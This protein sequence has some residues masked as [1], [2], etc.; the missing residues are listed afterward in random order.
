M[1]SANAPTQAKL[2]RFN[3]PGL[4]PELAIPIEQLVG[5][6]R[7][8]FLTH[9]PCTPPAILGLSRWQDSPVVLV[10]LRRLIDETALDGDQDFSALHHVIVKIAVQNQINLIGC[11]ILA[12]SQMISVPLRLPRAAVPEGVNLTIVHR[13]VTI[14]GAPVLLLD[15]MRLPDL[16]APLQPVL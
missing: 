8:P 3:V 16:I 2:F 9:V 1:T 5:V 14:D 12:G 4:E 11:P 10:D 13:A 7:L 15:T 6:A